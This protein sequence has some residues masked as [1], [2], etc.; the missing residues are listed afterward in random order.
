MFSIVLAVAFLG[1]CIFGT[2][3]TILIAT[4]PTGKHRI[5]KSHTN[6]LF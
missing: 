6:R 4:R 2:S 5:R 1:G 3:L